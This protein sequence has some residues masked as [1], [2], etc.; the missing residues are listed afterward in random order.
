MK[1]LKIA[2]REVTEKNLLQQATL[3]PGAWAGIRI[4]ALLLVLRGWRSTNVANLLKLSRPTVVAWI[5]DANVRGLNCLADR[6]RSGRPSRV[7]PKAAHRLENAL[8]KD[9]RD[10]GIHRPRWDGISASEYL[11]KV[12]GISIRPRQA[13]N[14][15]RRLGYVLKRKRD[16]SLQSTG[17]GISRFRCGFR[18][19][20]KSFSKQKKRMFSLKSLTTDTSLSSKGNC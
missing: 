15:L 8:Q 3:I 17:K 9:P 10:L 20:S 12:W 1:P 7:T 6:L 4:A 14:W 16:R 11:R 18:K 2:H 13:R 19:N 5:R